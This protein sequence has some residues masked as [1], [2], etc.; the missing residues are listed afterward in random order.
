M[1]TRK[2]V[3]ALVFAVL[4]TVP[5]VA[6]EHHSYQFAWED[7]IRFAFANS[8]ERKSMELTGDS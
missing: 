6:Q 7:C 4:L 8:N 5:A 1:V 3:L 2:R